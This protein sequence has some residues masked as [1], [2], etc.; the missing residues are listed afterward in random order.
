[1]SSACCR[2]CSP[3]RWRVAADLP[4]TWQ[5]GGTRGWQRPVPGAGEDAEKLGVCAAAGAPGVWNRPPVSFQTDLQLSSDRAVALLGVYPRER[6][7]IRTNP[8][9]SVFRFVLFRGARIWRG[10]MVRK[11]CGPSTPG[12]RTARQAGSRNPRARPGVRLSEG[13][14]HEVMSI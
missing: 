8:R 6:K 13:Q 5:G 9:A 12:T 1:M 2:R 3:A 4:L 11:G 10:W 7:P 14:S